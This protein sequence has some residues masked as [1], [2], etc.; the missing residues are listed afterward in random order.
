MNK[1]GSLLIKNAC[2][3]GNTVNIACEN[4]F[5]TRIEPASGKMSPA[6]YEGVCRILDTE[7]K[8]VIPAMI[9]PHV[10][11]RCPGFEYKEDW[12]SGTEAALAGGVT[13]VADMPNTSPPTETLAALRI[14]RAA[15][16]DAALRTGKPGEASLVQR[17]FWVG[18]SPQSINSLPEL[19][20][21]E[22]VAGVKLFFSQSS[23]NSSGSDRGFIR[24]VFTVASEAGKPAAVHSELGINA[25]DDTVNAG[26]PYLV[27]HNLAR[28]SSAATAGTAL[29]LELAAETGC[30]LYICHISSGDELDLV[31]RYKDEHGTDS[32]IAELTPHHLLLDENLGVSGGPDCWGRVNPPL[33]SGSFRAAAAAALLDGTIDLIGSD[34]APHTSEEKAAGSDGVYSADGCPSGFPGLETSL[35]LVAGF[36]KEHGGSGWTELVS[37]LTNERAAE[38]LGFKNLGGIIPGKRADMVLLGGPKIISCSDFKTKAKYSPFNLMETSVSV[39]KTISGGRIIG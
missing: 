25:L 35:P 36:L 4:G 2:L 13:A 20:S 16:A 6:E 32:V 21:E 22:D 17:K 15:A 5:I 7:G 29:A 27:N 23:F 34:H 38:V 31:R 1:P 18:S 37:M 14:K 3:Q 8:T 10:H 26:L 33:R 19:L 30:R 11:L 28:P 9:D 12:I 39:Y 24:K